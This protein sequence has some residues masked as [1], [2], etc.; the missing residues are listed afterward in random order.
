MTEI[1]HLSDEASVDEIARLLGGVEI[2]DAVMKNAR[3]MKNLARS[4]NRLNQIA[5]SHTNRS[6]QL[7]GPCFIYASNEPKSVLAR[8]LA[9][10]AITLRNSRSVF[11]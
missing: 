8:D 2:T 5:S 11:S 4:K 1:H 6:N 10:A 7:I 9:T 3:E